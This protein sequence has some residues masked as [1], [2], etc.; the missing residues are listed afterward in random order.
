MSGN[1]DPKVPPAPSAQAAPSHD[2][3]GIDKPALRRAARQRRLDA[4]EA[5]GPDAADAVAVQV[6]RLVA[7]LPEGPVGGYAAKGSEL[8]CW[9]ALALLAAQGRT[10]ALPRILSAD[11]PLAWLPWR[12][13][14]RLTEGRFGVQVPADPGPPVRPTVLLVPMLAFTEDGK[15]LGYGGGFFDRSLF[16]LRRTGALTAIGIAYAGQA[17]DRLPWEPHDQ[18]L[19][20]IVTE[21][22]AWWCH[23]PSVAGDAG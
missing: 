18:T 19:D 2:A 17:V 9:P 10:V 23:G 20:A 8:S 13:G 5:V 11:A 6:A 3:D 16:D 7:E 15:R 21:R 4:A 12:P 14:D 1:G 22:S